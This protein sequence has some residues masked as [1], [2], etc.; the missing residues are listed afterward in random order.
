MVKTVFLRL[1]NKRWIMRIYHINVKQ[2]NRILRYLDD[3]DT[4]DEVDAELEV[5]TLEEK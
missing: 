2:N 1:I 3:V 5:D 4:L